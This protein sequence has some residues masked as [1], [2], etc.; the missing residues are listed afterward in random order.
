ME[1]RAGRARV[2]LELK[3]GATIV[4]GKRIVI[5]G[6]MFTFP[7]I[8]HTC[9]RRAGAFCGGWNFVNGGGLLRSGERRQQ[10]KWSQA[11]LCETSGGQAEPAASC[12][13][14]GRRRRP[15][16]GVAGPAKQHGREL[17]EEEAACWR[18][19][20]GSGLLPTAQRARLG[21]AGQVPYAAA[22]A[23][24]EAHAQLAEGRRGG[25]TSDNWPPQVPL[26]QTGPPE[27]PAPPP[28]GQLRSH[29]APPANQD[30]APTSRLREKQPD[31]PQPPERARCS[32]CCCR[33]P[34][35]PLPPAAGATEQQECQGGAVLRASITLAHRAHKIVLC[36]RPKVAF[37]ITVDR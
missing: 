29:C 3:K 25:D 20:S 26:R 36:R 28:A 2:R 1:A 4:D 6:L 18:S 9:R 8:S 24:T 31:A 23:A 15:P 22:A 21:W 33:P 13:A 10:S 11:E 37:A 7:N 35:P 32:S 16:G 14:A 5:N 19:G 27:W 12:A 34:P 30:A 17:T